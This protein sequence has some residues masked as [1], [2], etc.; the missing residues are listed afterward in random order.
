MQP[1]VVQGPHAALLRLSRRSLEQPGFSLPRNAPQ[2]LTSILTERSIP[3][4]SCLS[5]T[6][7][8]LLAARLLD[9]H[10]AAR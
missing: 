6:R 5:G 7:G 2:L 4:S 1:G 3:A 9:P 10:R 8:L